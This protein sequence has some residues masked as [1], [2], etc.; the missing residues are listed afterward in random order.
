MSEDSQIVIPEAFIDL[1]RPAGARAGRRLTQPREVIAARHELCEDLAQMLTETAQERLHALGVTPEDVL[2]RIGRGL[3]APE[4]P[5]WAA[6]AGWVM[7]RL[8]ELLGWPIPVPEAPAP[9]RAA[10][11]EG[12]DRA[13]PGAQPG[14]CPRAGS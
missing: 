9:A 3:R 5:V 1:F 14:R 10:T 4:S 13:D 6:E 7:G 2:E 12:G 11:P 8:A